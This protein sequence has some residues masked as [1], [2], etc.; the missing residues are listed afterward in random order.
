[1]AKNAYV[2]PARSGATRRK[3]YRVEPLATGAATVPATRESTSRSL[4]SSTRAGA[5][6]RVGDNSITC[7]LGSDA[8]VGADGLVNLEEVKELAW[9]LVEPHACRRPGACPFV[10]GELQGPQTGNQR[11]VRLVVAPPEG[12]SPRP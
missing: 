3:R 4:S 7:G 1:V 2:G 10:P 12:Q 6:E 11:L 8:R 9:A 5:D